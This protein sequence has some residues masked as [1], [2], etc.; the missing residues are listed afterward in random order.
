MN[1]HP[2][3]ALFVAD[4]SGGGATRVMLTLGREFAAR[5]LRVDLVTLRARGRL[6]ATPGPLLRVVELGGRFDDA[7]WIAAKRG[8]RLIAGVPAFVR[9]LRRRKPGVVLAAT[10]AVNVAAVAARDMARNGVRVVVSEHMHFS[11]D[12]RNRRKRHQLWL[13]RRFYRRADGVIAVSDGVAA[14]LAR[15]TG[16]SRGEIARIYNPVVSPDLAERASAPLE[17]PW[18]AAGA[19]P[20]ILGV[21]RLAPPKD[22]PALLRAFAR[23][24]AVRPARLM[25][26]GEGKSEDDR[27]TLLAL[28]ERLGVAADVA[29]P[30]FVDNPLPY[31]ARAS[32]FVLS[33]RW[34]GLG[35]VVIEALACGCPVVSTD[36][37]SG[38]AEIL[39][40]GR[41]GTLVA[42]GDDTPMA[43]AILTILDAPP[44][45][46]AP[47]AR[48]A[49]FSVDAAVNQYLSVLFGRA[50]TGNRS[51]LRTGS[52]T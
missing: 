11:R 31:M 46:D 19:P 29:L 14:D 15:V 40:G 23:V 50:G 3:L 38:P 52:D 39:D 26:L 51:R 47:R 8:R 42:V 17:H 48:A 13:A 9:Y 30:G 45:G 27:D 21:G 34:E 6:Q 22:F 49:E 20:V 2:D 12:S 37:P 44:S 4:L 43:D 25:I 35:N 28:A 32:V 5:G 41:F 33:S 18:F 10:F 1:D 16:L 36:C 7:S 24:R